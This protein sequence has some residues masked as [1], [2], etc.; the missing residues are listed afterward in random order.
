MPSH[1]D[2]VKYWVVLQGQGWVS[3]GVRDRPG[4]HRIAVLDDSMYDTLRSGVDTVKFVGLGNFV[5]GRMV[6]AL[7]RGM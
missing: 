5:L 4:R 6:R 7:K 1:S 2:S 3:I